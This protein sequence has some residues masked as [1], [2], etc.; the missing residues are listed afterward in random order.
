LNC[1]KE[2]KPIR[3]IEEKIITIIAPTR[4]FVGK[5]ITIYAKWINGSP[6]NNITINV[7]FDK[8]II[9][10][11]TDSEGKAYFVPTKRGIYT[12]SSYYTLSY[13]AITLV[14]DLPKESEET[15]I[16]EDNLTEVISKRL[17]EVKDEK[18]SLL[19]FLYA[20][21]FSIFYPYQKFCMFC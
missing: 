3:K 15:T 6:A 11:L 2:E 10:L 21:N 1:P 14:E 19:I 7:I 16:A 13:S 18:K 9:S 5:N 12:Y 20:F 4:S 8:N 17:V